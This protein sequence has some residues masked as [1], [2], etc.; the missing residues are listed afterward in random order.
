M[1]HPYRSLGHCIR[2]PDDENET[3]AFSVL[4]YT[5]ESFCAVAPD[6]YLFTNNQV[7]ALEEAGVT[8]EYV[9]EPPSP[10]KP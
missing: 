3:L 5:P 2:F 9:S 6:L 8:F 4:R 7:A 1:N 10:T